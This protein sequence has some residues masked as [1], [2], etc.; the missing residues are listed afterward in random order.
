MEEQYLSEMSMTICRSTQC[1]IAKVLVHQNKVLSYFVSCYSWRCVIAILSH[2]TAGAAIFLLLLCIVIFISGKCSVPMCLGLS[3]NAK[4]QRHNAEFLT[5]YLSRSY[6]AFLI[7]T[8]CCSCGLVGLSI[9][10]KRFFCRTYTAP[11]HYNLFVW[12][13]TTGSIHH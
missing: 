9:T 1:N 4:D 7:W 11:R 5:R 6:Y 13:P 8:L 10:K 2:V 12:E 3:N